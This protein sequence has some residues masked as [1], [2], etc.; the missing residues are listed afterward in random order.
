ESNSG[1]KAG[2][3]SQLE[4]IIRRNHINPFTCLFEPVALVGGDD[5]SMIVLEMVECLLQ[6]VVFTFEISIVYV[7]ADLYSLFELS[8]FEGY[9]IT[10]PFPFEIVDFRIPCPQ[11]EVYGIFEPVAQVEAGCSGDGIDQS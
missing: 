10:L 7:I 11:V 9:K 1:C 4:K 2:H 3:L 6:S 8:L 5:E